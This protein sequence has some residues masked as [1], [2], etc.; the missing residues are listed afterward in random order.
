M[1]GCLCKRLNCA[2]RRERT[3]YEVLGARTSAVR[4]RARG[5]ELK[6]LTREKQPWQRQGRKKKKKRE[7]GQLPPALLYIKLQKRS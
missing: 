7:G 2:K 5:E 4:E 6:K 1:H 3:H